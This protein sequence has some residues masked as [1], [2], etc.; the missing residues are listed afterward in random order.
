[1]AIRRIFRLDFGFWV[2]QFNFGKFELSDLD[3][4]SDC[5]P[6]VTPKENLHKNFPWEFL[7]VITTPRGQQK[8]ILDS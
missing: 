3:T 2:Y 4:D 8:V 6:L 5:H 7:Y 1:M